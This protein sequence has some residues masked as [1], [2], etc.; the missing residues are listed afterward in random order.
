M[1][2]PQKTYFPIFPYFYMF[3]TYSNIHSSHFW[4][5]WYVPKQSFQSLLTK[6][7]PFLTE[8][9]L[10]RTNIR[11]LRTKIAI[12]AWEERKG[13]NTKKKEQGQA[14]ILRMRGKEEPQFKGL[15]F[16]GEMKYIVKYQRKKILKRFCLLARHYS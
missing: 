9:S 16:R 5:F 13:K 15:R 7:N 6:E 1:Q 14:G 10:L 8:I 2:K 12:N 4:Y 3:D 11:Y